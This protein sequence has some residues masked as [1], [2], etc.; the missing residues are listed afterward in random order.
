RITDNAVQSPRAS[1]IHDRT[2]AVDPGAAGVRLAAEADP[3]PAA[4]GTQRP[5]LPHA[6]I[7]IALA[8]DATGKPASL[9]LVVP[10]DLGHHAAIAQPVS[11]PVEFHRHDVMGEILLEDELAERTPV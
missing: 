4:I 5:D 11:R 9:P 8:F 3:G 2:G 6:L 7:G 10:L 1:E